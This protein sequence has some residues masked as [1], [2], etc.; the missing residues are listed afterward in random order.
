MNNHDICLA[1]IP[2]IFSFSKLVCFFVY[3]HGIYRMTSCLPPYRGMGGKMMFKCSSEH[4]IL[5]K[6]V[7]KHVISG[8]AASLIFLS[9]T[10]QVSI[11]ATAGASIQWLKF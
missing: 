4:T 2:M 5:S 6:L 8:I 9:Q 10:N 7:T 11:L 1:L 3:S